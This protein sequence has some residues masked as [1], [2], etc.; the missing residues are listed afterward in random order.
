MRFALR[1]LGAALLF[2]S[3]D[4]A[5]ASDYGPWRQVPGVS[6]IYGRVRTDGVR[7][8]T[9]KCYWE[10]ELKSTYRETVD[11]DYYINGS[12]AGQEPDSTTTLAPGEVE[13]LGVYLD[14]CRVAYIGGRVKRAK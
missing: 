9:G 13:Q 11:F 5:H 10:V 3:L 2:T 7:T 14:N 6:G 4:Q 1:L 12:G 8:S